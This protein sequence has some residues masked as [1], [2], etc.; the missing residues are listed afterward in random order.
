VRV[1]RLDD[2]LLMLV[3]EVGVWVLIRVAEWL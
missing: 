3:S 2:G 1:V